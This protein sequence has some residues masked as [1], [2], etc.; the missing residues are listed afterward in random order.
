MREAGYSYA[1]DGIGP[2]FRRQAHLRDATVVN[3]V[4]FQAGVKTNSFGK[5]TVDMGV[6]SPELTF[7]LSG[8]APDAA[9]PSDCMAEMNT[10]LAHL[11]SPCPRGAFVSMVT[12]RDL[13]QP[14]E[15]WSYRGTPEEL[16]VA[17]GRVWAV[18]KDRGE[19]WFVAM[20]TSERFESAKRIR[21]ER[22]ATFQHQRA[23]RGA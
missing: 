3:V 1:T 22:A 19:A 15:W 7:P 18:M 4:E 6:Y 14:D 23:R 2:I 13:A 12:G 17:F 8:V 16:A 20:T 21:A 5:F 9:R 10:R 11:V